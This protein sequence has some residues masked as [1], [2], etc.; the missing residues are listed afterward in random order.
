MPEAPLPQVTT[1]ALSWEDSPLYVH[2]QAFQAWL[3]R[4]F[5]ISQGYPTPVVFATPQSA[6]AEY[7]KLWEQ[8]ESPF[9]YLR[10]LKDAN[11][12][13]A[14]PFPG[15]TRYPL[16]NVTRGSITPRFQQSFSMKYLRR[17][18]Y[19]TV[20]GSLTRADLGQIAQ[21][22]GPAAWDFRFQ[23]DHFCTSPL[24]QMRFTHQ[25]MRAFPVM[26]GSQYTF[27]RVV[28]PGWYGRCQS[29]IRLVLEGDI[30]NPIW[31]GTADEAQVQRTTFNVLVEGY[32]P[33][34]DITLVPTLWHM[35]TGAL[36]LSA[37]A[38]ED[39][40]PVAPRVSTDLRENADNP[41]F[42]SLPNL[43]PADA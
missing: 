31:E 13:A 27:M 22:R 9:A 24:T 8:E 18:G 6:F 10:T 42:N 15:P 40:Y 11:G 29:L 28:Y 41:H 25:L 16:L 4:H 17:L 7:S 30:Q 1:D 39:F 32:A 43:P 19:P 3:Y 36:P 38:L 33:D 34:L 5:L 23:V 21:S 20:A 14:Y 37:T 26:T 35:D 2:N 12:Q